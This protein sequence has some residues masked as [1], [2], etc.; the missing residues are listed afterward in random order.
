MAKRKDVS[1]NQLSTLGDACLKLDLK[2]I[3]KILVMAE[4]DKE[5][6][7]VTK[8][9]NLKHDS[10][11]IKEP[12]YSISWFCSWAKLSFEE[13][14]EEVKDIQEVRKRGDQAFLE[15]DFETAIDCYSQVANSINHIASSFV[16]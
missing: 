6:V 15:Q 8:L 4:D 3:H 12:Y 9:T 7:E 16:Y 13:W 1:L 14:L 11:G 2:A 10:A 5:L